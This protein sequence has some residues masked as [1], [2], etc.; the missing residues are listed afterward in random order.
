MEELATEGAMITGVAGLPPLGCIP[1]AISV[2]SNDEFGNRK[3]LESFSSVA[4]S[5]NELLKNEISSQR[6]QS[7]NLKLVYVETYTPHWIS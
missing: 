5:Y 1:L 4:R 7:S 2:Y 6:Y 3:C